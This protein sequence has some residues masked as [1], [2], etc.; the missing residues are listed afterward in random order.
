MTLNQ[1]IRLLPSPSSAPQPPTPERAPT[2][3]D[4]Q[5]NHQLPQPPHILLALPQRPR[6][7]RRRHAVRLVR[8]PANL[9]HDAVLERR[10]A[11][12][13]RQLPQ[14]DQLEVG[15]VRPVQA[16]V[17][18]GARVEPL[19]EV[20]EVGGVALREREGGGDGLAEG[21]GGVEGGGEEGRDG[22]E[23]FDV[24]VEGVVGP[25]DGEGDGCLEEVSVPV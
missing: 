1:R 14:L 8:P 17:G 22:A 6:I 7:V 10:D 4:K 20:L 24:E 11:E 19:G 2:I 21:V 9:I 18:Q 15:R 23:G 12:E 13:A 16:L 3:P 25:A 5:I